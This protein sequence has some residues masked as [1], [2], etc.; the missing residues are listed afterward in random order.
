MNRDPRV[1][2]ADIARAG[3]DIQSY[4]EVMEHATYLR[5]RTVDFFDEDISFDRSSLHFG[6]TQG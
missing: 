2:L 4:T 3:A 5:N 1:L 6:V